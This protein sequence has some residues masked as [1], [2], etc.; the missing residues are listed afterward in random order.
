M[1]WF[2]RKR[3]RLNLA[4]QGGGAHGAFTWG[5]IDRLL[6]ENTIE[7]GWLSGTSAGA[8]NAVALAAG[9]AEGGR[10]GARQKLRAVWEAVIET[11]SPELLRYNPFLYGLS[12]SQ[13]MG[14]IGAPVSGW[15]LQTLLLPVRTICG[16][17]STSIS[18]GGQYERRRL[19]RSIRHFSSPVSL[20]NATR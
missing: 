10:T 9:L 6:E 1:F 4:L 13:T 12:R 16:L 15:K 8:I 14:Q 19:V 3:H 11:G 17:P 18:T 20:S 7:F 5:V 2:R